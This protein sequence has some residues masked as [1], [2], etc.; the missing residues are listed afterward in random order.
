MTLGAIQKWR[1]RENANCYKPSPY[2]TVSHFFHYTPS[3]LCYQ[4]NSDK[5]FIWSRT[6]KNN[7]TYF[8]T[9]M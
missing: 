3:P 5:L 7:F 1:Y 9:D 6:L 2:V 8:V 4:A